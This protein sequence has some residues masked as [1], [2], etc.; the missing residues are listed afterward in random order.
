MADSVLLAVANK[1]SKPLNEELRNLHSSP[2]I[3]RII[4]S[5]NM[6]STRHVARMGEQMNAYKVLEEEPKG[7]RPLRRRRHRWVHNIEIDLRVTG[8]DG[9]DWVDVAQNR[10]G[11]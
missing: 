1:L 4:Q 2:S 3:I 6:S 11:V 5:R 7:K 8:W 10:E 9:V